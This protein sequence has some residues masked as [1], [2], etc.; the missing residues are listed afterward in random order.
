MLESRPFFFLMRRSP[1]LFLLLGL[2][3]G[4]WASGG[5]TSQPKLWQETY[6]FDTLHQARDA[7]LRQSADPALPQALTGL[8]AQMDAQGAA[9]RRLAAQLPSPRELEG[10]GALMRASAQAGEMRR[11]QAAL[12][13]LTTR[14]RM[15]SSQALPDPKLQE[16]ASRMT[17]KSADLY[18][19]ASAI[20]SQ[21]AALTSALQEGSRPSASGGLQAVDLLNRSAQRLADSAAYFHNSLNELSSRLR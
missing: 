1:L 4:A 11:V 18:G 3:P 13:H 8:E 20:V 9:L 16:A 12:S 6:Y 10:R 7:G 14:A 17:A 2:S 5:S 15:A 21:A 19:A